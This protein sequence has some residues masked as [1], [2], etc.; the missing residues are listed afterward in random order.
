VALLILAASVAAGAAVARYAPG[1]AEWRSGAIPFELL[2][3]AAAMTLYLTELWQYR[4]NLA[5]TPGPMSLTTLLALAGAAFGVYVA[6]LTGRSVWIRSSAHF[7]CA[8]GCLIISIGLLLAVS[9][10]LPLAY[11]TPVANPRGIALL[12]TTASLIAAIVLARRAKEGAIARPNT[13][14][15][16]ELVAWA[17]VLGLYLT[18]LWQLSENAAARHDDWPKGMLA[19]LAGAGFAAYIGTL[20][21]RGFRMPSRAH[22]AA[23]LVCLGFAVMAVLY[24]LATGGTVYSL[25]LLQP[26]G[27]AYLALVASLGW[28]IVTYNRNVPPRSGDAAYIA[29]ILT[30]LC[31]AAALVLFTLEALDLWKVHGN[32][33]LTDPDHSWYARH[34]TLSIGYALYALI[35]LAAGIVRSRTLL[36]I[37]ALILLAGTIVKVFFYD[38]RHI[39]A[40]WRVLSVFGLGLLLMAGSLLY[41]KYRKVLFKPVEG[42]PQD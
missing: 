28:T 39:E 20:T 37:M 42:E 30:A 34:A 41:H 15:T 13:S 36:R 4:E 1:A 2:T 38:M 21:W 24:V 5:S 3:W 23:G 22:L 32:A 31:H 35:L 6:G 19:Y 40:I 17:L 16:F 18:E 27:V 7:V 14:V 33:W 25:V 12:M 9:L 11:D 8:A 10:A 29:P 26:R